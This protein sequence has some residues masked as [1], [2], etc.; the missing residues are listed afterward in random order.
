MNPKATPITRRTILRGFGATQRGDLGSAGV[1][2]ERRVS[3]L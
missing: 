3:T 1:I 2:P